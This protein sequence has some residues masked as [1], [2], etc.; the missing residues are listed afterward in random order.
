MFSII[1]ALSVAL[2]VSIF[3]FFKGRTAWHWFGSS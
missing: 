3:A 2:I 1:V